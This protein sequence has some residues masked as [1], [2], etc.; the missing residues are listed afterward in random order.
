MS[1]FWI[2]ATILCFGCNTPS[3]NSVDKW[4]E[5][6]SESVQLTQGS[7][8][9]QCD[10]DSTTGV[11]RILVNGVEVVRDTIVQ[12]ESQ[13]FLDRS[14]YV[15]KNDLVDTTSIYIDEDLLLIPFYNVNYRLVMQVFNVKTMHFI[16][17]ANDRMYYDSFGTYALYDADRN[18]LKEIVKDFEHNWHINEYEISKDSLYLNGFNYQYKVNNEIPAEQVYCDLLRF[19]PY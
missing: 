18:I 9:I 12:A 11:L 3:T 4:E 17:W 1:K 16:Q 5:T 10:H 7:T 13:F 6:F 2:Y 14:F 19:I 15:L 8:R